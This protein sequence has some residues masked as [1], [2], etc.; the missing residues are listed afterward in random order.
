M[1]LEGGIPMLLYGEEQALDAAAQGGFG[2]ATPPLWNTG[3]STVSE[4]FTFIA[5]INA[6]RKSTGLSSN[7]AMLRHPYRPVYVDDT[8]LVFQ[9]GPTLV[10]L[11]NAGSAAAPK[12]LEL[13]SP[14]LDSTFIYPEDAMCDIV[15]KQAATINGRPVVVGGDLG[16]PTV[17]LQ[18]FGEPL[19][20]C[21]CYIVNQTP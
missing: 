5:A 7:N 10:V 16:S 14:A 19:M 13:A 1:L 21:A 4:P 17:T 12:T 8:V 20:L 11:S 18:V 9:R 2:F 15:T 6:H 3:Y